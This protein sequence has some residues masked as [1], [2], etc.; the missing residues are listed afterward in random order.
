MID[1]PLIVF[2]GIDHSGKTTL[3]K[4]LTAKYPEFKWSHE[5]TFSSEQA[6]RLNSDE[7]KGQDAKREVLFLESRLGQQS[8]YRSNPVLL[9]RYLWTGIAY[10]KAFSPSIYPFCVELYQD[11][12]IFKK[13]TLTFFMETPVETCFE[14][15][16]PDSNETVE[17]LLTIYQAYKDTLEFVNTPVVF[18][19][20]TKTLTECIE[21][22]EDALRTHCPK[23]FI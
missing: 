12:N 10:A 6:D 15:K 8:F 9:D 22:A 13:P 17:R 18:I 2:E 11:Y 16:E 21:Q 19:D 14:R 20:G 3:S 23:Y 1:I 7:Y 4:A 5:P